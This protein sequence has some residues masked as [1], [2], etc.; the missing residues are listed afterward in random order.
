MK[1]EKNFGRKGGGG[2][3]PDTLNWQKGW[4]MIPDFQDRICHVV[5]SYEKMKLWQ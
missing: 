1:L 3:F 2:Y 5:L 4:S